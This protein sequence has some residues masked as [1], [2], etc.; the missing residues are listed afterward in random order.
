MDGGSAKSAEI[1]M[2]RTEV[3]AD[4]AR[5]ASELQRM[6]E[7]DGRLLLDRPWHP[8]AV[9]TEPPA[10]PSANALAQEKARADFRRAGWVQTKSLD[11]TLRSSFTPPYRAALCLT[12]QLDNPTP[13]AQNSPKAL[14]SM[15][16]GPKSL[17]I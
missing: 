10:P 5:Q 8:Q 3:I 17:K 12:N 1:A 4:E 13:K 6:Q 2:T 9:P 16:F 7:E 14:Y 11:S 15:V